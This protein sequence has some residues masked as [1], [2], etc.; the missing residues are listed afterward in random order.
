MQS[1]TSYT[2]S[3]EVT[4]SVREIGEPTS[5]YP[6][7]IFLHFWGGSSLTFQSLIHQLTQSNHGVH[8]LAPDFRGCGN[9]TGPSRLG[10][11][12]I[13]DLASDITA[14]IQ[15]VQISP[16]GYILVGH[17]MGGK[18]A[19]FIASRL[20]DTL[21]LRGL[22]LIAPAPLGKLEL[23]Q[24]AKEQQQHAYDSPESAEFVFRNILLSADTTVSSETLESLG[25]DAVRTSDFVK[26]AWP[27]Y[28]M[29][30]DYSEMYNSLKVPV[31]IAVGTDDRIET[32]VRVR[33]EVYEKLSQVEEADFI[34]LPGVGHLSIIEAPEPLAKELQ[35]FM[36][37]F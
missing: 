37:G 11:Y 22:F 29:A 33:S 21:K 8:A 20:P 25:N 15:R 1:Q 36:G 17:S 32:L 16:L 27:T 18:V 3:E 14:L 13:P 12:T 4:I 35:A 30:E 23:D 9:S 5:T 24:E 31:K 10:S 6:T 7:L 2:L 19:Q 34:V 28:G 26:R